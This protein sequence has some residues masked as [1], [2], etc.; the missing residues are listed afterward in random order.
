VEPDLL[1]SQPD[2]AVPLCT[3]AGTDLKLGRRL[4]RPL[5]DA[6]GR[7]ETQLLTAR[8]RN[9]R[10]PNRKFDRIAAGTQF[11]SVRLSG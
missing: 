6:G 1:R 11:L 7:Q 2:E 4:N 5:I 3:A 9:A 10:R 8:P